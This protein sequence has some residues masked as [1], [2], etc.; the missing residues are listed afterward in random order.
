[1]TS[2]EVIRDHTKLSWGGQKK[3]SERGTGPFVLKI[4]FQFECEM[5]SFGEIVPETFSIN[6]QMLKHIFRLIFRGK[7]ITFKIFNRID[8]LNSNY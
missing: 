8:I 1:M 2:A 7:F 6:L 5:I 3:E 4:F